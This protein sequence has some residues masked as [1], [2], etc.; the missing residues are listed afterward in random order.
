[1]DRQH[2]SA[3]KMNL[4]LS[5]HD[6][7]TGHINFGRASVVRELPRKKLTHSLMTISRDHC[8]L[9]NYIK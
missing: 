6:K 5:W 3:K 4:A 8:T 7:C 1:M 9:F 2:S